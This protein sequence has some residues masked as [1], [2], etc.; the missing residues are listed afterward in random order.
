M[1]AA[2]NG[3]TQVLA[4]LEAWSA[5]VLQYSPVYSQGSSADIVPCPLPMCDQR[6]SVLT[7]LC[8]FEC[9][10]HPIGSHTRSLGPRLVALFGEAVG[11]VGG[12][13]LLEEAHHRGGGA[14]FGGF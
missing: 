6:E 13:A 2:L 12:K 4:E 10:M 1:V 9:E 11:C 3:R 8:C 5:G 14:G 7:R